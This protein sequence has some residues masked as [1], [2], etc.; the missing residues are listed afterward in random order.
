MEDPKD[1]E[2]RFIHVAL[3]FLSFVPAALL[4]GAIILC[5]H[6]Y[7]NLPEGDSGTRGFWLFTINFLFLILAVVYRPPF[8]FIVA[9]VAE[10]FLFWIILYLRLSQKQ[11]LLKLISFVILLF[12]FSLSLLFSG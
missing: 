8:K 1:L 12:G 6:A 11:H 4:I 2:G 5:F 3:I 7:E 10:F 9:A